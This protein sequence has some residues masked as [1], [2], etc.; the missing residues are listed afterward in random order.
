MKIIVENLLTLSAPGSGSTGI[1]RG[2][3]LSTT[4]WKTG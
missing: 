2:G 3:A 4:L 1:T